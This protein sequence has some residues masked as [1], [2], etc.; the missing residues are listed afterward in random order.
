MMAGVGS[1]KTLYMVRRQPGDDVGGLLA[2][3]IGGEAEGMAG[4]EGVMVVLRVLRT[5]RHEGGY[6]GGGE[7]EGVS[8]RSHD[9]GAQ[10]RKL[11]V[12]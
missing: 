11:A 10:G 6:E 3:G 9:D 7:E 8:V 4:M 5:K 1:L 2:V 12:G